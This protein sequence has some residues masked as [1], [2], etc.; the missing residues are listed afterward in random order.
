MPILTLQNPQIKQL[1]SMFVFQTIHTY[2]KNDYKPILTQLLH[3][4]LQEPSYQYI[5]CVVVSRLS[6]TKNSSFDK[7]LK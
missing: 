1:K 4:I 2:E 6:H 7:H 3:D 5:S